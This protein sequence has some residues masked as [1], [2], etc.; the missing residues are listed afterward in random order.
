MATGSFESQ[1]TH[2]R[3][4]KINTR[5][6]WRY[7]EVLWSE[8]IGLCKK[9]NIIY[10]IIT[11]N[12]EPQK[13]GPKWCPVHEQIILLNCFF[14]V[15]VFLV[16][17]SESSE[18]VCSSSST[19]LQVTQS[20]LTFRCLTVTPTGNEPKYR[21]ISDPVMN[22]LIRCSSSSNSHRTEQTVR[23]GPKTD[24][25]LICA[26]VNQ[27]LKWR[28]QI[29]FFMVSHRL[30]KKVSW[31]KLI[32]SLYA[33]DQGSSNLILEGRCPAEFS[34]NLPQHTC[35]E[36]SSIPIKTLISCFRCV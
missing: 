4:H 27:T 11:C 23:L 24:E 13:N 18:T 31:W 10:N 19:D 16:E 35:L 3:Q 6:S 9:L 21:H 36:V 12:P 22:E 34:S 7:I 25:P 29:N 33:L 5:D 1:K 2:I 30:C 8:T 26:C 32:Y 20:K 14:D 28:G 17:Q 15:V